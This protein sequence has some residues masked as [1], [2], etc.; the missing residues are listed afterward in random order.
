MVLL[1]QQYGL[2]ILTLLYGVV[3]TA[4]LSVLV[5]S[6]VVAQIHKNKVKLILLVQQD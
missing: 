3:I 6:T 5:K 1:L 4:K 2:Y